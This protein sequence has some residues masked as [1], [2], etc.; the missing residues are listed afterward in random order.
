MGFEFTGAVREALELEGHI[1]LS[2]DLRACEVGGI[3]ACLDVRDVVGLRRWERAHLFPPCFRQ[4]RGD[5]DCLPFKISDGRAFWGCLS[6]IWCLYVA[7]AL[8]TVE[9]P[10]TIVDDFIDA[11]KVEL[12][13][14]AARR[15]AGQVRAALHHQCLARRAE[16]CNARSGATAGA[17]PT[18]LPERGRARSTAQLVETVPQSQPHGGR[19]AAPARPSASR[20]YIRRGGRAVCGGLA[21]HRLASLRRPGI[22]PAGVRGEG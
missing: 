9:Q 3:H 10:D 14:F 1:A 16:R 22:A 20:R 5:D 8:V 12:R 7:A 4:L 17:Q 11:E 18:P 19:S 15:R 6:V 2:V 21:S 13:T